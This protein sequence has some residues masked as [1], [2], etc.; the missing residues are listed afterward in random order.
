MHPIL[1]IFRK[2]LFITLLFN[3]KTMKRWIYILLLLMVSNVMFAEKYDLSGR[4][5]D[6]ATRQG[7][8][9]ATVRLF[10]VED[11]LAATDSIGRFT[12]TSIEPGIYR[13]SVSCV[14][15]SD[16]ISSEYIIGPQMPI[17]ELEMEQD[18]KH[19][20]ELTVV[21]TTLRK[22]KESPVSMQIIGLKEIEK[23]PGGNRDISRIIRSYP[24]VSYSVSGYR[25]DLIVRGGAPSENRFYLDGIEI[26][27]INHFATQGASGGAVSILNADMI[28]EVQFYTGAF[29]LDKSGALSSVMDIR[30]R[31]GNADAHSMKATLGASEVSLSGTGHYK[32]N[33][34][35]LFSLR[36]SYLQL[37]FKLFKLPFLPNFIDGQFKVKSRLT[38]HDEV[39]FIGLGAIDD[40]KLNKNQT[41]ESA[42][43]I[44]SYLPRIRQKTLTVGTVYKHY[45][46]HSIQTVSLGYNYLR[47][48]NLKYHDND[49]SSEANKTLDM[50]SSEQKISLKADN[51]SNGERWTLA[52]GAEV[53]YSHYYNSTF[54]RLYSDSA[55]TSNYLSRLG[56]LGWGAYASARY[57]SSDERL[58]VMAGLRFDGCNFSSRMSQMWRQF[59]PRFSVS[60]RF[61]PSLSLNAG[62]GMFHQLPANTSLGFKSSAGTLLNKQLSYI[63]VRS[64]SIGMEYNKNERLVLTVEGFYKYYDRSPL[65][66]IDQIPLACKGNDYGAVGNELLSPLANGRAYGL[67]A[68]LR[69]QI[70]QKFNFVT[71]LTLY[72]SEYRNDESSSYIASAWDNRFIVNVLGSYNL[73][74]H[75]SMGAKISAIGGAPYTPYDVDK[76]SLVE[77]WN[78]R[79]RPYYDYSR[80]NLERL[81]TYAQ[82]DIRIDKMYY[83]HK[84]MLGFYLDIQNVTKS[85]YREQDILM[86]TGKEQNPEAIASQQRYVMKYIKQESGSLLPTIGATV[87]F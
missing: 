37:L 70:P 57:K 49:E 71:S 15:Y 87:Q 44:L 86:S 41:G 79:G 60:Y 82:M 26:P 4:V 62:A 40:M 19:L 65:S 63:R 29:P 80:Y 16:L 20:N 61:T 53:Y 12:I 35:Y 18:T 66:V 30:L 43:Y 55:Y 13:L 77:A 56:I 38:P 73:R 50:K 7:I 9:N 36:Q 48:D 76:S 68:S 23:S 6:K 14:G 45:A 81:K 75:W 24:G 10:G 31:D 22:N 28:R 46:A 32:D 42:E 2:P 11:K 3:G 39:T 25:N 47:N 17:I 51:R 34:T 84:W 21:G 72:K 8:S 83:F 52:E 59:S 67:E 1:S 33:T 74:R 85:V 54:Q 64:G 27:N 5:I 78:A 69:W 58:T